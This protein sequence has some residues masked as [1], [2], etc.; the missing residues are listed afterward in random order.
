MI[1]GE[2]WRV[3]V[4]KEETVIPRGIGSFSSCDVVLCSV[5]EG[6]SEEAVTM[7]TG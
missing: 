4:L 2:G 5:V 7:A 1:I 3:T 6:G